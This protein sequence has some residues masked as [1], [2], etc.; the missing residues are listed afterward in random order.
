MFKKVM[1]ILYKLESWGN[2]V[3]GLE[4]K[5]EKENTHKEEE[6]AIFILEAEKLN[7]D[8]CCISSA[9]QGKSPDNSNTNPIGNVFFFLKEGN[10]YINATFS[11]QKY[12][13]KRFKRNASVRASKR[14]LT[15]RQEHQGEVSHL[16]DFY[17]Q[18]FFFFFLHY[19]FC[20]HK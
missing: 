7:T 16:L 5:S 11:A 20:Y 2:Y 4:T 19:V 17:S 10:N 13:F 12:S 6:K 14:S 3:S 18:S 1:K 8:F 9:S 15:K